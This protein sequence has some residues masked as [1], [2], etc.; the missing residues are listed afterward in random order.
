MQQELTEKLQ[1]MRFR[2]QLMNVADQ[3]MPISQRQDRLRALVAG[4]RQIEREIYH[5]ERS[6]DDEGL[7][8]DRCLEL[9]RSLEE[10]KE[11]VLGVTDTK[12]DF[13]RTCHADCRVK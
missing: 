10:K 12:G 6:V 9:K 3:R 7:L 13:F 11:Q 2:L 8:A 1:N 4:V 5:I